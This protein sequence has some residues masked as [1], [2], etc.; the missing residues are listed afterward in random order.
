MNYTKGEWGI[1]PV[2]D[3]T[4]WG[5]KLEHYLITGAIGGKSDRTIADI[6]CWK[7]RDNG[8]WDAYLISASP[9]M[10]DALHCIKEYVI[11]NGIELPDRLVIM[12]SKALAKAE[13]L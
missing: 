9:D 6:G 1:L 2:Q 12:A 3:S 13:G 7:D 8:V 10:Y 4:V 5:D 11:H